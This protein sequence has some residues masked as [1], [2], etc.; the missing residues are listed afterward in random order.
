MK[1]G[2]A[3][4]HDILA[5]LAYFAGQG[6]V[7]PNRV[8]LIGQFAGGLGSVAA[9][10]WNP[11]GVVGFVNFSGGRGSRSSGSNCSPKHLFDATINFGRT[12]TI[13]NIWIFV[14]EE[15]FFG[16]KLS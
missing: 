11:P 4:S 10:S 14:S 2:L 1:A 3:T 15:D 6:F 16:S 5:A 9:D 8:V 7:D 12:T 13:L